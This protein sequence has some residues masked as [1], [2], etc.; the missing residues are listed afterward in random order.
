MANIEAVEAGTVKV[1]GVDE[2]AI[3][4]EAKSLLDN[5]DQYNMMAHAVNPLW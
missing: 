1:V 4:G 2:A 5:K 3:Y